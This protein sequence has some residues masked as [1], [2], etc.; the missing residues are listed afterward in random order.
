[1][2][3]MGDGFCSSAA[4]ECTYLEETNRKRRNVMKA[5]PAKAK[6]SR[7]ARYEKEKEEFEDR[8]AA[9]RATATPEEFVK[10]MGT[11]D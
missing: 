11:P 2:Y 5:K 6:Q 1:M 8:I 7:Q 3:L 4:Q 10:E 9:I